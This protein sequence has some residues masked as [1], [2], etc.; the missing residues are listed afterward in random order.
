MTRKEEMDQNGWVLIKNI[1]SPEEINQFREDVQKEKDHK[2][3]LLSSKLLSK[4]VTDKRI[5]DSIKSCLGTDEIYYYGDSS[6]SINV[7][8]NGFHK[9][10]RDRGEKNSQEF[11]DKEYSI[12]RMAIYLQDHSKHSKGLCLRTGSHLTSSLK[13][14]KIEN[15]K[16]EIGDLVIW[17]LTTTH[18]A[19]ADVISMFPNH[20]FHPR[21]ARLIP[22]FMKQKFITPRI[23]IFMSFAK[24]DTYSND[25]VEYLKTRQYAIDRWVNSNY[26][27]SAIREMEKNNVKVYQGFNLN[28]IEQEKVSVGHM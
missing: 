28:E 16:S 23:A 26:E 6:F 25:Y 4:I 2:G 19:N 15:V 14:G 22:S 18:S 20:S 10:S 7:V 17:K 9:D 12:L 3:D 21:F 8:G 24:E 5:I 27:E 11:S 13:T 1:F